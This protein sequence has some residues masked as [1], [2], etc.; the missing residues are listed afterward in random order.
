MGDE[1]GVKGSR[2]A[3]GVMGCNALPQLRSRR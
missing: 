3:G 1:E 2:A